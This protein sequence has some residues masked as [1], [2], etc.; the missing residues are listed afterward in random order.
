M[1]AGDMKIRSRGQKKKKK[2]N[3]RKKTNR[4]E[5]RKRQQDW[6]PVTT[7]PSTNAVT[8]H[9]YKQ[10]LSPPLPSPRQKRAPSPRKPV[11]RR[12]PAPLAV[13]LRSAIPLG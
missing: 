7:I 12:R 9:N 13:L 1:T 11:S 10:P 8:T 4:I 3:S 5:I 2:E 6:K